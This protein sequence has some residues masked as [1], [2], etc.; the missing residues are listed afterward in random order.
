M[1]IPTLRRE[2]RSRRMGHPAGFFVGTSAL[3]VSNAAMTFDDYI[4]LFWPSIVVG[5]ACGVAAEWMSTEFVGRRPS[6]VIGAFVAVAAG[7]IV[8]RIRGKRAEKELSKL[9]GLS[10]K[11]ERST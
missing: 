2:E 7:V 11:S 6:Y 5:L 8:A 10:N 4:R 9:S 3:G 1:K